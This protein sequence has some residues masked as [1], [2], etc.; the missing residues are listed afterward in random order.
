MNQLTEK[1]MISTIAKWLGSG[2]INIFG[3]QMSGK[4]TQ[5][6]YLSELF[7][8]PLIGGGDILRNTVIPEHVQKELERGDLITT[9][10]Y[11]RIVLPYLSKEEFAGKPLI[12]SAVGRWEGEEQSVLQATKESGHPIKAVILLDIAETTAYKRLEQANR[13]RDDD[14]TDNLKRRLEEFQNKTTSVIEYYKT[15]KLLIELDG[16]ADSGTVSTELLQ[17]LY[18]KANS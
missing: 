3:R 2:S 10:D 16:E 7:N 18:Q 6:K 17:K 9:E 1:E 5:G 11:V 13:D 8:G 14:H 15:Q 12:L 4:D